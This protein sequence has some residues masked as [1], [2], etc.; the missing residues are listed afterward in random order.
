MINRVKSIILER[1]KL[2]DEDDYK[3]EICRQ[4][5]IQ[6]LSTNE[7]DTIL[8]LRALNQEEILYVSEVFEEVAYNLQSN[9]YIE[10]LK[11]ISNIYPQLDLEDIII[12][13]QEYMD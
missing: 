8:S 4:R 3:I 6:I 2:H 11:E 13:S 12:I 7:N 1:K 9:K 10:C 5:L